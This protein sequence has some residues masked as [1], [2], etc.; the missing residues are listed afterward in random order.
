[1]HLRQRGRGL[2][3]AKIHQ[4]KEQK[5]KEEEEEEEEEEGAGSVQGASEAYCDV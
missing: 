4:K 3:Y 2:S 1:M 5:E